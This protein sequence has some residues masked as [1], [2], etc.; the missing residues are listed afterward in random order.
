MTESH[1]GKEQEDCGPLIQGEILLTL[2]FGVL[3]DT[4]SR[5]LPIFF[6]GSLQTRDPPLS[7]TE[8]RVQAGPGRPQS[9]SQFSDL[10]VWEHTCALIRTALKHGGFPLKSQL[11]DGLGA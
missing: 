10:S 2:R 6:L 9:L 3:E 4:V 1:R 8:L 7:Q 5:P 11:P